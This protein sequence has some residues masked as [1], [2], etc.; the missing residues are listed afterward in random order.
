MSDFIDHQF[1]LSITDFVEFFNNE[2]NIP[3]NGFRVDYL[4]TRYEALLWRYGTEKA[5]S[6][7]FSN[8]VDPPKLK[9]RF[10]PPLQD[11]LVNVE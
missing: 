11:D 9:G 8:K 2:I 7:Y 10:T 1:V 3:S 5:K 6:R 4:H